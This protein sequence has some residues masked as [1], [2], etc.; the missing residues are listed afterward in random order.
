MPLYLAPPRKGRSKNY[1]IR[2]TYLGVRVDRSAETGDRG[3]AKRLLAKIKA[4]IEDGAFA[5]RPKL[6]FAEAYVSYVRA[7]GENRFFKPILKIMRNNRVNVEDVTQSL[8]DEISMEIYPNAAPATRNRQ[9]YTPI[10]AVLS[11][12]GVM[13]KFR[14]PKGAQGT[15]R[16][17]FLTEEE[18]VRV[19]TALREIDIELAVLVT[20]LLYTGLR[21]SEALSIKCENIHLREELIVVGKT[22]NGDPR[23]VFIPPVV[24]EALAEHPQGIERRGQYLFSVKK[25]GAV[26]KPIRRAYAQAG[27]D[28]SGAPYHIL[29]HTFGRMMVRAGADLVRTN[30]WKSRQAADVYRHTLWNEEARKAAQLPGARG[31]T[32]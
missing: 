9:V 20:L 23:P 16:T 25:G 1:S 17:C 5:Q 32:A 8:V 24:A 14:R 7:G 12:A 19:L 28:Y 18:F 21:L 3:E 6:T 11:H 10:L 27:V 30:V 29:R 26:Y 31:R 15:P 22:K 2:G 4:A 13:V